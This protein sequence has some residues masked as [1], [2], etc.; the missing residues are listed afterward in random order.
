MFLINPR[1][2]RR[3][4]KRT[5]PMARTRRRKKHRAAHSNPPKRRRR[6]HRSVALVRRNNPRLRVAHRRR[7]RRNPP[8]MRGIVGMAI[9]GVKDAAWITVGQVANRSLLKVMPA[10]PATWSPQMQSVAGS[11]IQGAG[12]VAV[13]VASSMVVGR[14]A[15]RF[16]LAGA[17]ASAL[18]NAI[19]AVVPTAAP[20]LGD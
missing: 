16:V 1:G 10:L 6:H 4:T 20:L 3:L 17:L 15:A 9:Q 8:A 18:Q 2:S 5:R 11:A 14:E 13:G 12:A 19:K 7:V